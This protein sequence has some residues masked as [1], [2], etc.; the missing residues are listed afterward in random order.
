MFSALRQG[1]LLHIIE[2]TENGLIY[3]AG[4]VTMIK[5]HQPQLNQFGIPQNF[6]NPNEKYVDIEVKIGEEVIQLPKFNGNH[7]IGIWGNKVIS[8]NRDAINSELDG[9]LCA[10]KQHLE[11]VPYHELIIKTGDNIKREL[12]P[13]FAKEKEQE[14]KISNLEDK[15]GNIEDTLTN[16]MGMLSKVL[17]KTKNKED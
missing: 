16:M 9:M 13:Q 11:S 5:E 4:Q 17:G 8:D 7:N 12:N 3:K 10:S 14:E 2:K 1:N 6:T 15:M